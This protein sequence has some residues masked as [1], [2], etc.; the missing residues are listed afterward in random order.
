MPLMTKIRESLSTFFSIFAGVFVVYIVLD[1]G[2]DITGRKHRSLTSESQQ[3]GKINGEVVNYREFEDLVRQAVENQKN[4]TG[5]DPDENQ[6]SI[7]R[8]QVWNQYVQEK[9]YAEEAKK[10]NVSVTDQEIVDWVRGDAPPDFLRQQFIDSTGT[11]NRARYEATILDPRNKKIMVTV[12][13]FLRKQRLQEKLQ[14]II[15]ASVRVS[16]EEMLLRFK[17]QNINYEADYILIDPN[18]LVPDTLIKVADDDLRRYYNDH[19]EEFKVEATRKLKYVLFKEEPSK[20]D[21]DDVAKEFQDI[22]SRAQAGA[23]F[24]DLAKTYSEVPPDTTGRY[25]KHGEL[26]PAREKAVF[27]ASAGEMLGPI[28]ESDGYHLTKVED[29]RPGTDEYLHASHILIRI[30]NN[31]SVAALRKAKDV[32]ARARGGEDFASLARQ[33]S[34]DGSASNGGDLGW[35]GKG[36]MV[37]PFEEAAFK[38]KPG[39]I[40]GPVHTQFGYHVIKVLAKDNREVKATDIKMSIRIGPQT[41]SDISQRAKDFAYL[42]KEDDFAREAEQSKYNVQE[43]QP[44]QKN[45]LIPGIGMNNAVNKFAFNNKVGTVG[46]AISLQN[47][48]GVF[49]VSERKDAGIRPF[50]E[51][52]ASIETR[53]KHDVKMEKAKVIAAELRQSLSPTDS[54]QKISA[55]RQNLPVQHLAPFT[56]SRFIPGIGQDLSFIGAISSLKVGEISKPI[57]GQRGVYLVKLTSKA[58]FDSTGYAAQKDVLRGQLLSEKRSKYFSEWSDQLKKAAEIVDNRDLFYR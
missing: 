19:A 56:L 34:T 49:I 57:E 9:L 28:L 46:D 20:S 58:P 42:A 50:D 31:D 44:F 6:L 26:S 37:K 51:L 5:T 38:A 16:E 11:F 53:V 3:I 2:M 12:E 30:D 18:I 22:K 33:F 43:T 29:F 23:D 15:Y 10:L 39:Q 24:R 21:T 40:V 48:Y 54:L 17:D 4:Q 14:S 35:F 25:Y 7:I 47:G 41:K 8:D 32:T 45:V 13:D 27:N 36:K 1:W 55:Q 52:K